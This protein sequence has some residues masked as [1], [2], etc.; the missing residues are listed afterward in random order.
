VSRFTK[1]VV[2]IVTLGLASAAFAGIAGAGSTLSKKEYL[3]EGNTICKAANVELNAIF[4]E[5]FADFDENDVLT[6][7]QAQDLADRVVPIFDQ[8]LDDIDALEGPAALDKKVGK[9]LDE[10]RSITAEVQADPSIAFSPDSPDPFV[11]VDK[12][13]KKIGLKACGQGD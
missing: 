4:D 12:K 3:K 6:D 10:Y 7:E 8:A 11:E 13:A 9:V 5:V 1:L 2:T